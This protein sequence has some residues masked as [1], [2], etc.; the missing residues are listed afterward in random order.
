MCFLF[1]RFVA[2]LVC[3]ALMSWVWDQA[4]QHPGM[5]QAS[6]S[7]LGCMAVA[8]W[9]PGRRAREYEAEHP[10]PH[11]ALSNG[12]PLRG[13]PGMNLSFSKGQEICHLH[14][15]MQ[16]TQTQYQV[17]DSPNQSFSLHGC[18]NCLINPLPT[19]PN[20][21]SSPSPID[22]LQLFCM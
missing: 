22:L 14:H 1:S 6:L 8:H 4:G 3:G 19:D 15:P 9:A 13:A 7:L 2:M 16:E 18:A 21:T 11:H 10:C 20:S 17:L 5:G 12:F